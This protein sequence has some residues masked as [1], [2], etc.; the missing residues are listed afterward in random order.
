MQIYICVCVCTE[1]SRKSFDSLYE[2]GQVLGGGGFGTV[3]CARHRLDELPVRFVLVL[4]AQSQSL[5]TGLNSVAC[6]GALL[7]MLC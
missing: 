6:L 5:S 7:Y 1:Y 2:V 3:Y 4:C